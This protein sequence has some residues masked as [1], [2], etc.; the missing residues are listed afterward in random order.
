MRYWRARR[1]YHTSYG[2]KFCQVRATE[3]VYRAG[4]QI[5][6][7]RRGTSGKNSRG[8]FFLSALV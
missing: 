7:I 3:I 5:D 2:Y 1:S 6:N 8:Q 4:E